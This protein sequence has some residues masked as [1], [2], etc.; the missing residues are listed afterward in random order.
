MFESYYII[1]L[2][3]L[4]RSRGQHF[5]LS[6]ECIVLLSN[7]H[8]K[9]S[10]LGRLRNIVAHL[11]NVISDYLK[12]KKKKE[13]H[14]RSGHWDQP[15]TH[16][17]LTVKFCFCK[18]IHRRNCTPTK[19]WHAG[20]YWHTR[21]AIVIG[22]VISCL[23]GVLCQWNLRAFIGGVFPALLVKFLYFIPETP[24]W[25]LRKKKRTEALESLLWLRGTDGDT[26]EE[27]FNVEST[28]GTRVL[29]FF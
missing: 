3:L 16:G 14:A 20:F 29:F 21:L 2:I 13:F 19:T 17:L 24:L 7:M 28:I 25:L 26:E 22:F 12:E 10:L 6:I 1:L 8:K 15:S 9:R 27:C 23:A 4:S 18:G 11:L 5:P